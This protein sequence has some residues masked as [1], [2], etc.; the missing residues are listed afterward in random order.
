[1]T[2][3]LRQT[4]IETRMFLRRKDELLWTLAF[5]IMFMVLFGLIYGDTTWP[6]LNMRS[7]DFLL[8]GIIVMGAMVTGIMRTSLGF[9]Q[10][11]E[12][13]IYRRLAVTPLKRQTLIGSH[14]LQHYIVIIVQT[15][16]LMAVGVMA[17][18]IQVSGNP[19]LF[20]LVLSVG[21]LCF[22]SIGFAITGLIKAARSAMPLTQMTYFILMFLG[23]IFFPNSMLPGA[24]EGI[25]NALP[26]A[27]MSEALRMVFYQGAGFGDIW[28]NLAI[29]A[30]WIAA[31]LALSVKVFRW[32]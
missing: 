13:G 21:S 22:M 20:W 32:E 30:A 27:Q 12:K 14:L 10:E 26:S 28:Q 6:G 25:A 17:F 16:L 2:T 15:A 23:G 31:A 24:L 1:M 3:L 8:P 29:M 18:N 9:V 19:V 11:R 4:A 7:V 5:P